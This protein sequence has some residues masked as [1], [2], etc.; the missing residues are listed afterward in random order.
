MKC[1]RFNDSSRWTKLAVLLNPIEL[2]VIGLFIATL[3]VWL[4]ILNH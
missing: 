1:H 2:V 3:A 4:A